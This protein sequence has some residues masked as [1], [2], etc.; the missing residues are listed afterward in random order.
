MNSIENTCELSCGHNQFHLNCIG[1]WLTVDSRCPMC[2][3]NAEII[4]VEIINVEN[5]NVKINNYGNIYHTLTEYQRFNYL[6]N[7][8]IFDNPYIFI[9]NS[10]T[11][12]LL[13]DEVKLLKTIFNINNLIIINNNNLMSNYY[14][15]ILKNN[16][17]NNIIYGKF[18]NKIDD[19]FYFNNL[20]CIER[21]TG[22][23]YN[24]SP[25]TRNYKLN[26][27][28]INENDFVYQVNFS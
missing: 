24:C 15:I 2:R 6:K 26:D 5:I 16:S 19:L 18:I 7:N 11:Q 4:N 28:S 9:K 1:A 10:P 22:W 21:K 23:D 25:S 14:Y 20:K 13:N 12:L 8:K 3:V 17:H 27:S